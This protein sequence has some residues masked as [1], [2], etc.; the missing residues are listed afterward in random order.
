MRREIIF[1]TNSM[2]KNYFV[3]QKQFNN[4]VCLNINNKYFH[5]WREIFDV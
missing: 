5:L 1:L 2:Y 3:K 4:S